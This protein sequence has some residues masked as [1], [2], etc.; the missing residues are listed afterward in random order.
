MSL[1]YRSRIAALAFFSAPLALSGCS[2]SEASEAAS[3]SVSTQAVTAAPTCGYAVSAEVKKANK[4][5]FKAKV[6]ITN[7]AGGKLNSTAFTVLV[8]ADAG[9]L[10]KVG[11]GTFQAVEGGY[12]LGTIP[13]AETD[14]D[15]EVDD[16]TPDPDVLAGKAYRFHLKFEGSYTKLVANIISSSGVNC[17]QTAPSVRLTTSGDFFTSPTSLTLSA[18]TSDDGGV[19]K[20][21]FARDGVAIGTDTTAPYSLLVPLTS[22][23]NG[24]HRYTATAYDL[25]GN[26]GSETQRVLVAIGN[27]FFGTAT[28][29]AA[30]YTSLLA[31]FN[32]VTPG[33]AGKWGTVEATQDVM[34]WVDLD[35]AYEFA[36]EN[37]LPFKLH[38][39]VWGAQQP[40]WLGGLSAAEQLAELD[41]WMSELAARY[42]NVALIDVVNEPL[43]QPPPYA[44]AL[45]GAGATG[46]DWVVS[47]FEMARSH[48]PNAEL[49]LNDYSILTMA[50]STQDYLKIVKILK[51]RGL[52]DGIGEQGHFYERTPDLATI[53]ANLGA[54]Q[55]TGLPLYIS[56]L[57]LNLADDAQQANRMRDLFTAFWSNPSVLGITHWGYLQSNVWQPDSHL[58][59]NDG[60]LRPALTWIECFRAGGPSCAVPPYV[61]APH[62][63]SATGITLEAEEFD[64]Y[65]NLLTAGNVVAYASDGSWFGYSKVVYQTPWNTLDVT[66]ANGGGAAPTLTFHLDSLDSAP[67]ATVALE[68]TGSWGTSKTVSVPWA[69]LDVPKGL[70]VKFNG[71]GANIDK[72]EF[73]A[74][75]PPTHNIIANGTFEAD[76]KGWSTWNDGALSAVSAPPAHGG[77]KSLLVSNR[78]NNAPAVTDL[79]G[80]VTPGKSYPFTLWAS[81]PDGAGKQLNVTASPTCQGSD[82]SP[83]TTYPWVAV[84]TVPASG[85]V[86]LSG[87]IAVPS[88]TLTQLLFWVEG[89]SGSDLY[90]DDV[91][92]LDAGAPP[93]NLIPDGTFESGQGG[94]F[95]WNYTTLGV[96]STLANSGMQS[97]LG[98]GLTPNAALARD[99]TAVVEA[100]KKYTAT[101][102]VTVNRSEGSGLAKW[103]YVYRCNSAV[104]DS[105]GN[106]AFPSP[107]NGQWVQVTGTLDLS[108]CTT[109][110][111]LQLFA[112]ADAGDLYLDDVSLTPLP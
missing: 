63:G 103:Q 43:H 6:K 39:L 27:K 111:K 52:I 7:A 68:P 66:Y 107:N 4:K 14:E 85:W 81:L 70:Y 78:A 15:C 56:E 5:G 25:T 76:A 36:K 94:W 42:P 91:E 92:I 82:G 49:L 71:G 110:E 16:E 95:G 44:A 80:L 28:T 64:A 29:T 18:T 102:W 60:S 50:S 9:K 48:F 87:S 22:A 73:A 10:V 3:V 35:T 17:D 34:N 62:A 41:E 96:S 8:N 1:D 61:P 86:Q 69:P 51:D 55:A 26:Q 100:G 46:W 93:S 58:V 108:A 101:G 20:V 31:H 37:H 106:L 57:D 72:L 79:T 53:T 2:T 88:C 74:P 21:V 33:N 30:D 97:L 89:A 11:H 24:R 90:L 83:T 75:P 67:V 105:Y 98:A 77:T 54:L 32:Q 13:A 47:S 12:L 40:A 65:S 59:R 84:A 45:G 112:G 38:T 19:S 99:I 23:S 104:G 109:V